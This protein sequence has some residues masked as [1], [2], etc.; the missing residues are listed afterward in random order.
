MTHHMWQVGGGEPSLKMSAPYLL[1]FV[2]E[3]SVNNYDSATNK[4]TNCDNLHLRHKR[5]AGLSVQER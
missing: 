2:S 5:S 4:A 1:T 3:G